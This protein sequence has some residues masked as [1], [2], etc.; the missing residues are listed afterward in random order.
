[1][2]R[3]GVGLSH[4]TPVWRS[5]AV[6][7]VSFVTSVVKAWVLFWRSEGPTRHFSAFVAN[8]PLLPFDAWETPAWRLGGPRVTQASPNPNPKPN[9]SQAEGRIAFTKY[10][11]P[12]TKYLLAAH[13]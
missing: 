4:P 3:D 2:G 6:P 8:K 1:M 5:S 12:T 13:E 10:Q 11:I 9:P 7:F